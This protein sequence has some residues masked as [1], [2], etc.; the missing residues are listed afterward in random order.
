M[1]MWSANL[2]QSQ[3]IL[4]TGASSGI[5]RACAI[6]CSK[7]G[8]RIIA[9]GRDQA[10]LEQTLALLQ[11]ER[12]LALK[13]D[14]AD[15]DNIPEHLAIVK[16]SEPIAG[17]I[18]C[19]GIEQTRPLRSIDYDEY[20]RMFRIN[21]M[22]AVRIAGIISSSGYADKN[23]ASYILISSVSGLTGEKGKVEY[24]STKSAIYAL[25]KSLAL[26]LAP[27][28]IAVNCL[29]PALVKTP[30]L[31]SMLETLPED[32][33]QEI[34]KKHLLGCLETSDISGMCIFLLSDAGRR[35]TGSNIIID[36]GYTLT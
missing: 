24:S 4:I 31:Q 3:R 36:S 26:E 27:K 28:K 9:L 35:I 22:S 13:C 6:D 21:V 23:G 8:A 14:L 32:A 2:L 18:H 34:E 20:D 30:M 1:T 11:G 17:F 10:R 12:H 29:S 5:G 7:L 16:G 19:A 15:I 25:V 33:F